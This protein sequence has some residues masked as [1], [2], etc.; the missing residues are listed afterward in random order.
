MF[1]DDDARFTVLKNGEGQFSLW[2]I[3]KETPEGWTRLT[4]EGSK[5]EC[6]QYVDEHWLDMR[7]QS[8]QDRMGV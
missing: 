4:F 1:D 8:L 6:S 7:P 5:A 2:P 3:S